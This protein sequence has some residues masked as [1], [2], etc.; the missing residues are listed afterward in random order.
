MVSIQNHDMLLRTIFVLLQLKS[1]YSGVYKMGQ[2]FSFLSLVN[3]KG[4]IKLRQKRRNNVADAG[5]ENA[6]KKIDIISNGRPSVA[7]LKFCQGLQVH[8]HLQS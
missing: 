4:E 2:P 1:Y 8:R 3:Y 6:P 7:F 5:M